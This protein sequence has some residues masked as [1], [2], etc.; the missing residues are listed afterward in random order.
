M[1]VSGSLRDRNDEDI[2]AESIAQ[3]GLQLSERITH[4]RTHVRTARIEKTQD[5][6][7]VFDQVGIEAT[8]D[9]ILIQNQQIGNLDLHLVNG[10]RAGSFCGVCATAANAT[11]ATNSTRAIVIS[12]FTA[13]TPPL[14]QCESQLLANDVHTTASRTITRIMFVEMGLKTNC[15]QTLLLNTT[16]PPGMSTQL[17][18]F[19]Y[20]T[21]KLVIPWP[22]FSAV[23]KVSFNVG[24]SFREA[25]PSRNVNTSIS[26]MVLVPAKFTCNQS[27]PNCPSVASFQPPPRPSYDPDD[28]HRSLLTQGNWR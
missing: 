22:K 4:D 24:G 8:F 28:R 10:H 19:Q 1:S 12:L 7:F 14:R 11:V 16:W 18:P 2:L 15:R 20:C 9:A 26:F 21:L 25:N 3:V 13:P 17:L 5:D 23:L 27:L 6:D